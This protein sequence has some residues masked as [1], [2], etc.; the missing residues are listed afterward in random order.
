MLWGGGRGSPGSGGSL[1]RLEVRGE[2]SSP[3]LPSPRHTRLLPPDAGSSNFSACGTGARAASSC[4]SVLVLGPHH[5]GGCK[6]RPCPAKTGGE[7]RAEMLT[8]GFS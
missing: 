2:L 4:A 1:G 3:A 5:A 8:A 7:S 6:A